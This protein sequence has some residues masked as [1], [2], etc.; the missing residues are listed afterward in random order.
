MPPKVAIVGAGL[1]GLSCAQAL[2]D[3]GIAV[4]IYDKG[5]YPGG[6]LA[7]RDRDGDV[8][9]YGAQYFTARDESFI[10]FLAPLISAGKVARWTG[11]FARMQNGAL[12][13]DSSTHAKY[14]AVPVMRSLAS[15]II[16]TIAKSNKASLNLRLS[17][18]A[19]SVERHANTWSIKGSCSK[20]EETVDFEDTG[21]G[22][23]VLN[24]PPAQAM[25]LYPHPLLPERY[26]QPCMALSL[27]FDTTIDIPYDGINL[28]DQI[29][30]WVA[31]DSSKPGRPPGERWMLHATPYWSNEQWQKDPALI[32]DLM[33]ER[34][35]TLIDKSQTKMTYRKLHKWKYALPVT[36]LSNG[37]ISQPELSLTYCGDWCQGARLESAY[38]SGIAASTTILRHPG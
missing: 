3:Q 10:K 19:L 37:C 31:R 9:D 7:S 5:R 38:L 32:E 16:D 8:F 1:A 35:R 12:I 15:T 13:A 20:D 30:A 29:L 6:R 2:I 27:S 22:H 28:E 11:R 4:T 24:L 26:L 23:L 36:P 34:F 25:D 14:V 18:R 17:H 21:Y 33:V